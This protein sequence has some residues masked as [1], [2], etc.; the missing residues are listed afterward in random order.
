[1]PG[2][3]TLA[4]PE[5]NRSIPKENH[6]LSSDPTQADGE[7]SVAD[8]DTVNTPAVAVAPLSPAVRRRTQHAII[9]T[10]MTSAIIATMLGAATLFLLHLGATP[11]QVGLMTTL[12][13]LGSLAQ[14]GGVA[15]MPRIGKVSLYRL[16][17]HSSLLAYAGILLLALSGWQG[18]PA[19]WLAIGLLT[20]RT[21]VNALG[22]TAWW[23]LLQ[24]ATTGDAIGEFFAHMRSRLRAMDILTPLLV[25]AVLG[26]DPTGW[27]FAV[28][29]G[30]A[31]VATVLGAG[32]VRGASE[33][34]PPARA[35]GL[36]A[37][38]VG[39]L[40]VSSARRFLVF[41]G[42]RAGF[43]NACIPFWVVMLKKHGLP[44]SFIVWLT[45]IAATGHILGLH[46]WGRMVD[47]YGSRPVLT[48]T[49][50]PEAVLGA[51]WLFIPAADWPLRAWAAGL[52]L[53]WGASEGGFLMG[54]TRAMM[55]AIPRERQG[56]GFAVIGYTGAIAGALGGL[57][58]GIGF[59]WAMAQPSPL[60]GLL[61]LAAVQ[62]LLFFAWLFSRRLSG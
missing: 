50:L 17:R 45:A 30:L 7:V 55:D 2:C 19:V 46:R 8:R 42:V 12:A 51:A 62:S 28:I 40:R 14:L 25:G 9:K 1:M 16:G 3:Y 44:D 61:Y 39:L 13:A 11:F 52:Y 22:E 5:G 32:F 20:L 43:Y 31:A 41:M 27:R 24:D 15:L 33:C 59:G 34:P 47:N 6:V 54:Y 36:P 21:T 10:A 57:L 58:G 29:F 35:D 48:L 4:E 18:Q 53:L 60:P 56:E 49:M 26:R 38:I 23:P 37:R